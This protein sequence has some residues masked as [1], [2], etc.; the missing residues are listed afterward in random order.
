MSYHTSFVIQPDGT[1]TESWRDHTSGEGHTG[2]FENITF[3][4]TAYLFAWAVFYNPSV[5]NPHKD[6]KVF[7]RRGT[8]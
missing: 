4:S 6:G 5:T 8:A 7:L 3:E 2:R 1:Y